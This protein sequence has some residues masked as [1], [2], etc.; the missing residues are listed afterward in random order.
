M[1][2]PNQLINLPSS[3][4]KYQHEDPRDMPAA[5]EHRTSTQRCLFSSQEPITSIMG[6]QL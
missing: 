1:I 5:G 6:I 3:R 4:L 2:N